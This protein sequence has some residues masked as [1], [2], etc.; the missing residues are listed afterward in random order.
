MNTESKTGS[1]KR[2]S[3]TTKPV[4]STNGASPSKADASSTNSLP[5]SPAAP[6][7]VADSREHY[8]IDRWGM[9]YFTISESGNLTVKAPTANGEQTIEFSE[10]LSG[11]KQRGLDMPVMLRL[12][13]LVDD[14]ITRLNETFA[15]AIKETEYRGEYQG[16]FPI[17]VN[18]QS[19]VVAEI[20]RFGERF[21]HCLLYT[22]PSPRDRG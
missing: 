1:K 17:K 11:L 14:R 19:H 4:K 20:A 7:S 15:Q 10:I 16:V 6:W 3:Q 5:S 9:D 8:G 22:Y 2:L 21:N 12:E 18:Q 13:N